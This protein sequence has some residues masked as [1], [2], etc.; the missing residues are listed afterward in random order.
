MAIYQPY[1]YIIQDKRNGM[2]YAGAK[3]A[4]DANPATFMIECGYE[5]S[6]ETIRELI[7]QH[8]H[9]NF[10]IRKLRI[11]DTAEAAYDYETR[12][13]CKVNAKQHSKFYNGHNNEGRP[14]AYGSSDFSGIMMSKYGVEHALQSLAIQEKM[15]QTVLELYGAEHYSQT[16]DYKEKIAITS[17]KRY[18]V[19]HPLKSPAIRNLG[20]LTNLKKYGADHP[21]KN[22]DVRQRGKNTNLERNGDANFNNRKLAVETSRKKYGY[23]HP[24]Q[25]PEMRDQLKLLAIDREDR[26]KSRPQV[27][28]L[29][30]YIEKFG[31]KQLN[32]GRGWFRKSDEYLDDLVKIAVLKFGVI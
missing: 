27:T 16:S 10:I 1:F 18:G 9:D 17:M 13:L 22:E 14:P 20:K 7:R 11:F 15:K 4:R 2:Y 19:D 24:T 31:S 3:W 30:Q 8:G 25:S 21:M 6:S 12:F 5:T 23:D 26:K 29:R 32:C 28:L